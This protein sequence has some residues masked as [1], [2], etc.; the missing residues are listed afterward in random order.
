MGVGDLAHRNKCLPGKCQSWIW[1]PA[2]KNK[3]INKWINNQTNKLWECMPQDVVVGGDDPEEIF[4]INVRFKK[5][6][7]A[8]V[9]MY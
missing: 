8:W 1:S 2:P 3:Q 5:T 7:T 9:W 4:F 6:L